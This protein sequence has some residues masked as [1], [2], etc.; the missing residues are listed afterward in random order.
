MTLNEQG[1]CCV[2]HLSFPTIFNM[3]EHFRQ[4]SIPLESG[5]TSDVML[6]D[7]VMCTTFGLER[8]NGPRTPMSPT[9]SPVSISTSTPSEG[10]PRPSP[11]P[12]NREV[13]HVRALR[14]LVLPVVLCQLELVKR[15]TLKR[16]LTFLPYMLKISRR[17]D[18]QR[19]P[20]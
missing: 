7:Y 17:A 5:G 2:Q 18:C 8:A 10:R 4:Y 1:Q 6:T 15:S 20:V 19:S 9:V 16:A 13:S 12:E 14:Y 3:L 11:P